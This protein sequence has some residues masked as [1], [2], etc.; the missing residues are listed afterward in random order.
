MSE[1]YFHIMAEFCPRFPA[2]ELIPA[3]VFF[4]ILM[5]N[6]NTA[7][8]SNY[9]GVERPFN[10][11]KIYIFYVRLS[12]IHSGL[13]LQVYSSVRLRMAHGYAMNMQCC[14]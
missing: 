11:N 4:N 3:I 12:G 8:R 2:I 14:S 10:F 7:I 5:V 9:N 6:Y 13:V 1:D